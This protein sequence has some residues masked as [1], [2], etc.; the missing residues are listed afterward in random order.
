MKKNKLLIIVII[1]LF[2][3]LAG[4]IMLFS[5][6]SNY[7]NMIKN[8]TKEL[9]HYKLLE[10][11]AKDSKFDT[12]LIETWKYS[13]TAFNYTLVVDEKGNFT[14]TNEADCSGKN[15]VD[16]WCNPEK[17]KSQSSGYIEQNMLFTTKETDNKTGEWKEITPK[18]QTIIMYG[19]NALQ[20][21]DTTL[22]FVKSKE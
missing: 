22:K 9:K 7:K 3:S 1:I 18:F 2:I 8:Q 19:D 6:N 4:N 5:Q 20:I 21:Q 13:A 17:M 14:L 16:M 11:I 10:K 12:R 15:Y